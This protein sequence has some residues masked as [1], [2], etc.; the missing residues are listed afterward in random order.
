MRFS[1]KFILK[2]DRLRSQLID[3]FIFSL[4]KIVRGNPKLWELIDANFILSA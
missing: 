1:T 2:A 4:K 3:S